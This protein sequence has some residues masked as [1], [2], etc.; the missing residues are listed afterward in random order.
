MQDVDNSI[1]V[2]G[3]R[4]RGGR[5]RLR[6]RQGEGEPNPGWI[7]VANDAV[8]RLPAAWAGGPFGNLGEVIDA[9]MTAH[10]IG[11][12]VIGLTPQEGVIDPYHRVHGYPTLRVVDGSHDHSQPRR[13]SLADH[14]RDGRARDGAVA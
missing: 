13:E 6:S 5:F 11:G 9:P 3:E 4:T 8:R 10:F 1:T 14:H 2:F 7:P 12:A